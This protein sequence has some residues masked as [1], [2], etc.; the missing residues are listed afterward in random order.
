MWRVSDLWIG[1]R[2]TALEPLQQ[3]ANIDDTLTKA[4]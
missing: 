3:Q 4:L 1:S 2:N